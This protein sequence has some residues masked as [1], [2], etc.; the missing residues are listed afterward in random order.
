MKKSI[1]LFLLVFTSVAFSQNNDTTET[2]KAELEFK[3][4]A[5]FQLLYPIQ[6]GNTALAKAHEARPGISAQMNLLDYQHFKAGFG[7]DFVTYDITDQQVIANLST[8]KYTS[9]YFLLSYE[10][11][12]T[13]KIMITPN[14]GYG[15]GS[16]E[17]GSRSSRFGK[18]HG[19]ELRIGGI[20]DYKI[21]KSTYV[22]FGLNYINN[23]FSVQTAPEYKS[24]FSKANQIQLSA[25]IRFGN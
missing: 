6:F 13:D 3:V 9:A 11:K 8:S 4:N 7:F 19:K 14:F 5:R 18:Q 12:L 15:S 1:C 10:Y 22:F 25:G 21:G 20:I 17:L 23:R 24:F 2:K 16:L